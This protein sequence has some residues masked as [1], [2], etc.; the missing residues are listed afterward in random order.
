[1]SVVRTVADQFAEVLANAGVERIYGIVGDS[2]NGLADAI[3]RQGK[4]EW[5]YVRHEQVAAF[6]AGAEAHLTGLLAVCAGSC[7][8]GNLDLTNGL[9]ECHLSSIPVLAVA[10]HIPS[11][12]TGSS[13][14]QEPHPQ[15]RFQECSHHCEFVSGAHQ[16]PRAGE[17]AIREGVG[18]RGVS[19]VMIPSDVASRLALNAPLPKASGR[20]PSTP[21]VTASQKDLDRPPVSKERGL[22][23]E[24]G[25]RIRSEFASTINLVSGAAVRTESADVKTAPK[26]FVDLWHAHV[27]LAMPDRDNLVDA[28][29]YLRNLGWAVNSS[30]LHRMKINLIISAETSLETE[31]CWLLA[32]VV[33]ELVKNAVRHACFYGTREGKIS[34]ELTWEDG[35]VHCAVSDN[36]PGMARARP[37]RG[38]RIAHNLARSLGGRI[39]HW[40]DDEGT[41]FV[42]TFPFTERELQEIRTPGPRY[43]SV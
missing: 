13:Y 11:A 8:T 5:I 29:E 26:N 37:V 25:H 36:G 30:R 7:G 19:L 27:V 2:L 3:R 18:R 4:I 28:A 17:A 42:V 32:Q 12:E 1:M 40:F 22:L 34:I 39:G 9:F 20:L 38:L 24:R 14:L 16:L 35:F 41:S 33:K 10:A 21:V 31:R 23:R 6:A 43:A 15:T